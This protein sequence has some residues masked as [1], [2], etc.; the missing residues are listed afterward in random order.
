MSFSDDA[1]K[2]YHTMRAAKVQI[3]H[4]WFEKSLL[5][6][7]LRSPLCRLQLVSAIRG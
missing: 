1:R 2:T 4:K 6:F 5:T 7:D 3:P